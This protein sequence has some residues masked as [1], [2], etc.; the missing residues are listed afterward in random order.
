MKKPIINDY[1][2]SKCI[3]DFRISDRYKDKSDIEIIIDLY[4]Y[5][6]S[7]Y[8]K[9]NNVEI[10]NFSVRKNESGEYEI[11]IQFDEHGK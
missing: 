4:S 7:Q 6:A 5:K 1:M 8:C 3:N 10:T 11:E 9:D 2:C